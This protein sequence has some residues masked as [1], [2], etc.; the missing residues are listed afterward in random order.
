MLSCSAATLW[1][2]VVE[3]GGWAGSMD[4]GT[5]VNILTFKRF[6][7][8]V[9]SGIDIWDVK[10]NLIGRNDTEKPICSHVDVI[11]PLSY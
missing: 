9:K 6:Q 10:I 5:S 4:A 8:I 1:C 3:R 2:I 11:R 7:E